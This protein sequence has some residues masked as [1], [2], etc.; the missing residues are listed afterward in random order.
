M[1]L[2]SFI[3]ALL[4]FPKRIPITLIKDSHTSDVDDDDDT[5]QDID[6]IYPAGIILITIQ[7]N[8]FGGKSQL[9]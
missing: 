7:V 3:K 5:S 8:K 9:S 4:L 1:K 6:I 2:I